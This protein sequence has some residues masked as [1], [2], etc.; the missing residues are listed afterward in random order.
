MAARYVVPFARVLDLGCGPSRSLKG[1][2]PSGCRHLGADLV[3]WADDVVQLDLDKDD[4]P[5]GEFDC[6]FVLGVAEYLIDPEDLYRRARARCGKL[7]TSFNFRC[8]GS[9]PDQSNDGWRN[10]YDRGTFEALLSRA[11]WRIRSIAVVRQD[12]T[13]VELL[14]QAA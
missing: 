2:L 1:Y 9:D 12:R 10:F 7:V 6:V 3:K 5:P 4:L 14:Y 8:D 11:G 13:V